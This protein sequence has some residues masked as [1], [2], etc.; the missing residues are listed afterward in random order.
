MNHK[1]LVKNIAARTGLSVPQ[2]AGTVAA[3]LDVVITELRTSGKVNLKG[4]GKLVR[5]HQSARTG[6]NPRTGEA[7]MIPERNS[8]KFKRSESLVL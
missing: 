6:R 4:I 5:V 1:E 7:V 2:T 3:M 8:V